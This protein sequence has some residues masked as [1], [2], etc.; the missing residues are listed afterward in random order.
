ME[1][2]AQGSRPR[3]QKISEAKDSPFEDRPFLGQ[4]HRRKCSPKK[5]KI[6]SSK[7]FFQVFSK[8]QN[9][10]IS[11]KAS[12]STKNDLQNFKGSKNTKNLRAGTV[13][14]SFCELTPDFMKL[15]GRRPFF[16]LVFALGLVENRKIL[17]WKPEFVKIFELKTFFFTSSPFSF[18]PHS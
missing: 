8:N 4:G 17:R 7:N 3:K 10:K 12:F 18:D 11:K 5:K 6:M 13:F 9:Q 16:F 14:R 1:L 2:R 15:W